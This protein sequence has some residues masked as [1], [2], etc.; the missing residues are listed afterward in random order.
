LPALVAVDVAIHSDVRDV[1]AN[2]KPAQMVRE[3]SRSESAGEGDTTEE[4][5]WTW[6]L[7][8]FWWRQTED[9]LFKIYIVLRYIS[10]QC[11]PAKPRSPAE[12]LAVDAGSAQS[13]VLGHIRKISS[14]TSVASLFLLIC[15]VPSCWLRWLNRHAIRWSVFLFRWRI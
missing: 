15:S 14:R 9:E 11:C 7:T 3:D 8:L 5:T 2:A 13:W 10:C 12:K 6:P 4:S 1:G